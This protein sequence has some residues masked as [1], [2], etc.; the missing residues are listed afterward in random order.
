MGRIPFSDLTSAG[1]AVSSSTA[2]MLSE[3]RKLGKAHRRVGERKEVKYGRGNP[4]SALTHSHCA[5]T[6]TDQGQDSLDH[7][8]MSLV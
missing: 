1:V 2:A 8:Q 3:I 7:F 5:R 4:L 6:I